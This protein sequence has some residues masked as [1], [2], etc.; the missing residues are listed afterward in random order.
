MP[1]PFDHRAGRAG[2]TFGERP[3]A[4]RRRASGSSDPAMTRTGAAIRAGL[5]R[6]VDAGHHR[7]RRDVTLGPRRR[8][9]LDD[10]GDD[11][12]RAAPG[13]SRRGAAA[14]REAARPEPQERAGPLFDGRRALRRRSARRSRTRDG[15]GRRRRSR[16]GKSA[17]EGRGDR[18][19][20]GLPDRASLDPRRPRRGDPPAPRHSPP[21]PASRGAGPTLR[22]RACPTR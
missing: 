5:R 20:H 9:G 18:R 22:S 8:H 10:F 19:R 6:K 15:R 7:D 12:L 21:V 1:R 2:Q 17:R 4:L 11:R 14:L 16:S 3:A 13:A